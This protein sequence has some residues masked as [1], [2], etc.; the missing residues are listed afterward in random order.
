MKIRLGYVAI[1]LTLNKVTSSSLMTYSYYKKLNVDFANNKLDK[2]IVSNLEDLEKIIL[3][4]IRNNIHFYRLSSQ[5]IPLAT[6]ES[7]DFEYIKRYDNYFKKISKLI[8]DSNMRVDTHPDQFC[9]LNSENNLVVQNSINILRFHK[10]LMQSMNIKVP[11]AVIHIGSKA[12]GK[13]EAINRFKSVFNTLD[14]SIKSMITIENDDKVYNIRNVLKLCNELNVPMTLDFHHYLCN[15]NDEKIEDY[16]EKICNTWNNGLNPKIHFS[17]S[18]GRYKQ[19]KRTHNDYID[20]D[21]FI[22]F[23]EKIKFINRDIDIM[24]EAK[25]KDVAL[26]NLIREIKYKTE[27][28]MIDDTTFEVF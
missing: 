8:N 15:N 9:V 25:M 6:H 21:K 19:D 5:I 2:I 22:G 12:G 24:L 28:K 23:I 26:F 16:I 18:K 3:Y 10:E 13:K 17:S 27:Y 1:A 14:S 11:I 20:S 7:V 4:N